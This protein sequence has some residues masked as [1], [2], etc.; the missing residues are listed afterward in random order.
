M[1]LTLFLTYI[2]VRTTI[3]Q[4]YV[5]FIEIV[6]NFGNLIFLQ[7]AHTQNMATVVWETCGVLKFLTFKES[8]LAQKS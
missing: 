3:F 5:D 6:S 1:A 4:I 7:S 2:Y 8:F